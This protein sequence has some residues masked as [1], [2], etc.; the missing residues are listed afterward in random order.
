ML[1]L[2]GSAVSDFHADLSL[3]LRPR[4]PRRHRRPAS[5]TRPIAAVV[6]PDGRWRFPASFDADA[7]AAAT[8]FD[9]AD[10][11]AHLG[12]LG[13]DVVLPQMFCLPGM[14]SYRVAVRACSACPSSAT[15]P[16]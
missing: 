13:L 1:H 6:S 7:I 3:T 15:P 14:T 5:A 8:P 2:A 10:A 4:L 11:L 16:R 9:P 12:A